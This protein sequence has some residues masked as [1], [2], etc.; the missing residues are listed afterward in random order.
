MHSEI[1]KLWSSK[2]PEFVPTL[3]FYAPYLTFIVYA[4]SECI[5]KYASQILAVIEPI[6]PSFTH[7]FATTC[8]DPLYEASRIP[9]LATML[10]RILISS[11]GR[12][13]LRRILVQLRAWRLRMVMKAKEESIPN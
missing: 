5:S 9:L 7:T 12:G 6:L 3:L 11:A 1:L 2:D 8:Y 4:G 10:R 13:S